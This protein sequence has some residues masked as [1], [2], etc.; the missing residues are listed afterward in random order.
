MTDTTAGEGY[1]L[2]GEALKMITAL[3]AEATRQGRGKPTDVPGIHKTLWSAAQRLR[4]VDEAAWWNTIGAAALN[5]L[6]AQPSAGAQGEDAELEADMERD[7]TESDH[8][9][10]ERGLRTIRAFDAVRDLRSV[11]SD[12]MSRQHNGYDWNADPDGMTLRQSEAINQADRVATPSQ[13]DTSPDFLGHLVLT[14]KDAEFYPAGQPV[15]LT[16]GNGRVVP[17]YD[18]PKNVTAQPDTGDVAA[19]REALKSAEPML[20]TLHSVVTA[21]DV[22]KSVWA[23]VKQV[24]AALSKPNA[25]GR[26]G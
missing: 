20:E 7:L 12:T 25:P 4:E 9:A 18:G 19:L 15:L 8:E 23:V 13:P 2:K 14:G 22:R 24:R 17:V 21:P 16:R 10:I 11:L 3:E 1:S 26:E 6:A 5:A